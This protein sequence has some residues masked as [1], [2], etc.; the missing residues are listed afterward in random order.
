MQNRQKTIAR[1]GSPCSRPPER[2]PTD[3]SGVRSVHRGTGSPRTRT[4]DAK[5]YGTRTPTRWLVVDRGISIVRHSESARCNAFSLLG[6]RFNFHLEIPTPTSALTRTQRYNSK[7]QNQVRAP[8]CWTEFE[9]EY[10]EQP[11]QADAPK[12]SVG[13]IACGDVASRP[14]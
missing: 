11:E 14:R 6:L 5:A 13:S 10:E 3:R 4:Q 12:D 9:H 2:P 7:I 1:T 8:S